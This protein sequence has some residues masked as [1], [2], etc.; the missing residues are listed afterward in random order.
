MPYLALEGVR[1]IDA[2]T[3]VAGPF[4]AKLLA[5]YGAEVIKVERPGTGD[6]SR[7]TGPFPDDLHHPEKSGLFLHLNTNKRGVTLD[8][9]NPAGRDLFRRL[10]RES[11]VLVE[12]GP[13]GEM[14][15]LGLGYQELADSN[16]GLVVT[17]ITPFGQT[18]PHSGHEF[19]ELT[20]FAA[21]GAMNREGI[22][23]REPLKYC[24]ETAQYFAGNA[25]A[26]AT[27]AASFGSLLSGRGQWIDISIQE[28]MTG[29]PHQLSRRTAF[30]YS[31]D[32]DS[33]QEPHTSFFSIVGEA[34]MVGTFR[35]KDGHVSILPVG[36]SMWPNFVRMVERPDL[37]DNPRFR[38]PTE[39]EERH[40]EL[41]A[42]FQP[43][44]DA[45]TKEQ[46]FEAAHEAG[47]PCGPVLTVDEV[48][49]DR[50]LV[51][52]GYFTDIHHPDAG[53]LTYTGLPFHLSDVPRE[54]Q[55]PAPRLGQ[56]NREVFGGM[57][58][59]GGDEMAA[60][61]AQMVLGE[62]GPA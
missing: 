16:P 43:W 18:G 58:G 5:D 33:R 9:A 49:E 50:H 22:P 48:M 51:D 60:L 17:S 19:T 11:D 25:A 57:L 38:D 13:P 2:A 31:A 15:S 32:D 1:V 14:D 3:G 39:R 47:L 24:G 41:E 52:R 27:M 42:I 4:C 28:C 54:D 62:S 20:V 53:T 29:H 30:A 21:T 45:R 44:L 23:A 37:L 40:L 36:S 46:V 61:E 7:A 10:V 55:R 59:V 26:A 6:S 56:H 34:Y 8:L 12:S 35:C